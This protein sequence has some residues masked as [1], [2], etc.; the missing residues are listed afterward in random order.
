MSKHDGVAADGDFCKLSINMNLH[1]I[2]K[3]ICGAVTFPWCRK[4]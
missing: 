4:A 1:G 2:F 3:I